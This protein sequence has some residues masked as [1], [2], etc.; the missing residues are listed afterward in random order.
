VA[1]IGRIANGG[2]ELTVATKAMAFSGR[3]YTLE[4]CV[5]AYSACVGLFYFAV[6][7]HV[8]RNEYYGSRLPN[9]AHMWLKRRYPHLQILYSTQRMKI[10][11]IMEATCSPTLPML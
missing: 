1:G 5:A 9:D 3:I 7:I 10:I 4:R 8:S 11:M 2:V 6:A